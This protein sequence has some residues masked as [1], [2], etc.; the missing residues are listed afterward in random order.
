MA[1]PALTRLVKT[2]QQRGQ[3]IPQ[4]EYIP[5]GWDYAQRHPEVKGWD[6]PDIVAVYRGKWPHFARIVTGIGP[7]G[8]DHQ[9]P[10]LASE[11]VA[12]HNV[13]MTFAYVLALA[14]RGRDEIRLLDWGGGSGHYYLL[15]QALLPD[16]VLDYHSRDLPGMACYGAELFPEQTFSSDDRWRASTYDLV[17]ASS[18]LQYAQDWRTLLGDLCKVTDDLLYITASPIVRQVPSFVFVQRPYRHGYNTEYLGWCLNEQELLET[19]DSA[20]LALRREFV[21]GARPVIRGA[22]EQNVY[23]GYLFQRVP[24]G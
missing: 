5:E 15:A 20:G 14:A 3:A 18:S 16:L 13:I 11:N 6:V 21:H 10:T 22:P 23:R 7:L 24:T 17:M 8:V 9:A 19:V 12:N 4:W 2:L 1:P